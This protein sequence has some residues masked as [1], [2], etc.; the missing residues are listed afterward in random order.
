MTGPALSPQMLDERRTVDIQ[1]SAEGSC[2]PATVLRAISWTTSF[3]PGGRCLP[4]HLNSR[5]SFLPSAMPHG[6]PPLPK[7][8]ARG[9]ASRASD[10]PFPPMETS[11][12]RSPRDLFIPRFTW[13]S[14]QMSPHHQVSLPTTLFQRAPPVAQSPYYVYIQSCINSL[15]S[16]LCSPARKQGLRGIC[17]LLK[18]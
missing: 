3:S 14:T 9:P 17:A 2:V 18:R 13:V 11:A 12:L 10:S 15:A 5:H 16:F 7:P 4:L 6:P 1:A 8:T